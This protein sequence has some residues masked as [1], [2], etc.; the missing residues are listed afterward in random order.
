MNLK[1]RGF[2]GVE[3]AKP[4]GAPAGLLEGDIAADD[5]DDVRALAHLINQTI[6]NPCQSD[7]DICGPT[8]EP[9]NKTKPGVVYTGLLKS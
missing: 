8:M 6:R 3:R 2:F 1:G 7:L 9:D 5:L 4:P